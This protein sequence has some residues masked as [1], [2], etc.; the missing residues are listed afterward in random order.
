[1]FYGVDANYA[2]LM[3]SL[4][5]GWR[6][7]QGE[8]VEDLYRYLAGKGVNCARVRLWVGED[9]PSRFRYA[10]SVMKM[11]YEA[12]MDIYLVVFLSEGW[13]DLYK[14]PAP[15]AWETL[16]IEKKTEAVRS[17]VRDIVDRVNDMGFKPKLYQV[18]N[19]VDYGICGV[20]ASNKKRRKDLGWLRRRVWRYEAE[21]LKAALQGLKG[22]DPDASIAIHLGKWWDQR[23]IISFLSAMEDFDIDF[24]TLCLSFYPSMFGADFDI[25]DRLK[26]IADSSGK[27]CVIA[28][29]AYPSGPMSGRFWFMNTP[30][31]GYPFT[32][33]GQAKWLKDFLSR[34]RRL[35]FHG[36]F[37]WS[38]E[39]YLPIELAKKA[40]APPEMPLSFGWSPMA[41][42]DERGRAKL[43]I[44]SFRVGS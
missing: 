10:A 38:P 11:A 29:Y 21:I 12:G 13:A 40:P 4:G 1:M 5:F 9:G 6:T 23:L 34:C 3:E 16:S 7:E 37:Y 44:D 8:P 2:L 19:E 20:F 17:Y 35:G 22:V 39:V 36:A 31:P 15:R 14:Q 27:R 28:E 18:G 42:F 43:S 25:L 24:D 26:E 33:E 32:H 41:L 30:T